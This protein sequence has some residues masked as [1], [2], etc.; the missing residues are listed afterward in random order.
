ML[1]QLRLLLT[2]QSHCCLHH[3][4]R[5]APLGAVA[6]PVTALLLLQ[7]LL[8]RCLLLVCLVHLG[9]GAC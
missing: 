3:H 8:L 5:V 6:T 4:L 1:G 2:C 7:L 9:G